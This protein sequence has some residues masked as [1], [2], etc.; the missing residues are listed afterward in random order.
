M[1]P[2]P[3]NPAII[4]SA[5]P[6]DV[7]SQTRPVN[8][9]TPVA[10]ATQSDTPAF[11]LGQKYRAQIGER[12]AN[13][14]SM[15]NV[16]GK[17]L[18]MRMPTSFHSGD[19]LELTLI[20]QSP[21]LKFLLQTE[22]QTSSIATT[23]SSTGKLI[24]Q[25]LSQS[26][27]PAT[28]VVNNPS[29]LLPAPP[30]THAEKAQ[31]LSQLQ[32]ALVTSGLFYEA[33]LVRWLNGTRSLQQLRQ[34]PQGKLPVLPSTT[35]TGHST[36]TAPVAPQVTSLV[37]QQLHTLETG[38]IQWRGEIWPGQNMDWDITEFRDDH[39]EKEPADHEVTQRAGYWQTCVRLHLP[40]LGKIT[41]TLKLDPQ[42][43]RIQLDAASNEI[44]QQLGKEQT[45]LIDAMRSTGL[46]IHAIEIQ[47]H[48]AT[49][50]K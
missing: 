49:Q 50:I 16:A 39:Q 46:T 13:G 40:N 1:L 48:E 21:R 15:V 35:T 44:T 22:T 14:H 6:T 5:T 43:I 18:Q 41:A 38:T 30:V 10:D 29:P 27:S 8:A 47:Q 12:L 45:A 26:D 11:I 31:L 7:V 23:L 36:A 3:V 4:L 24:A 2:H 34:E 25:L 17:W 19:L 28:K 20:E 37:Q 33:H 42:G 9:T 32:Q